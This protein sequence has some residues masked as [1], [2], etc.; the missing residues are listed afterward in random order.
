MPRDTRIEITIKGPPQT[1]KTAIMFLLKEMLEDQGC[2]V[3][4][5]DEKTADHDDAM[6]TE[7]WEVTLADMSPTVTL[8]EEVT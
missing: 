5:A 4:F 3:E 1:G 7:P 8:H 6:Q 2:E